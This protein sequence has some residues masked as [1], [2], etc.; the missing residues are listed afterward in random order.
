[1]NVGLSAEAARFLTDADVN[2]T[3]CPD[4][5][6]DVHPRPGRAVIKTSQEHPLTMP[7][8]AEVEVPPMLEEIA[9]SDAVS[10]LLVMPHADIV[11][12]A[13]FI[14]IEKMLITLG[15]ALPAFS[16]F[17][18][19][20]IV[21]RAARPVRVHRLRPVVHAA[22]P[23]GLSHRAWAHIAARTSRRAEAW[24]RPTASWSTM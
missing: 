9:A 2:W 12:L 1:M 14:A 5:W 19:K 21:F 15:K 17:P 3:P 23:T 11:V 7:E 18:T 24:G 20:P 8:A 13:T 22:R 16:T 6:S 10:E 4:T